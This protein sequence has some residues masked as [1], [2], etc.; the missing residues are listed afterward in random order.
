[1]NKFSKSNEVKFSNNYIFH[2]AENNEVYFINRTCESLYTDMLQRGRPTPTVTYVATE[3]LKPFNERTI[4]CYVVKNNEKYKN[5]LFILKRLYKIFK[6]QDNVSNM[7]ECC[8]QMLI[9][10][11]RV[12]KQFDLLGQL[13]ELFVKQRNITEAVECYQ[14]L[15]AFHSYYPDVAIFGESLPFYRSCFEGLISG[16]K[17]KDI[18]RVSSV[19]SDICANQNKP[20]DS[21]AYREQQL[22]FSETVED[23]CEALYNLYMS[24]HEQVDEDKKD[25]YKKQLL[26]LLEESEEKWYILKTLS[27]IYILENN[28]DEIL[29]CYKE[30]LVDSKTDEQKIDSLEKLIDFYCKEKDI[31]SAFHYLKIMKKHSNNHKFSSRYFSSLEKINDVFPG[32]LYPERGRSMWT[33]GD[34][35]DGK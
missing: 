23:R 6:S 25:D 3:S 5:H 18:V 4:S 32:R 24:Y 34:L 21:L 1:M 9:L 10:Q 31:A 8:K 33:F 17:R 19:L 13:L 28:K 20:R 26:I 35:M 15:L 14:Q 11:S 7:I 12:E 22:A 2:C 27:R 30:M 29:K 16:S